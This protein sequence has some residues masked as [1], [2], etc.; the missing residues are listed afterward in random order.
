RPWPVPPARQH[1]PAWEQRILAWHRARGSISRLHHEAE[2]QELGEALEA[3]EA[4]AE[5][6]AVHRQAV[7]VVH[8]VLARLD[9]T[10]QAVLR[11]GTAGEQAGVPRYPARTRWHSFTYQEFG[12]GAPRDKGVLVLSTLGRIAVPWARPVAGPP[13]TVTRSR[14]ADGGA[15]LCSGA[16]VPGQR[17]AA[18]GHQPGIDLGSE[19]F[20]PRSHGTRRFAPSWDR[21]AAP[22]LKPAQ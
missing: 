4:L 12:N 22:A 11:R 17:V 6:A 7:Q 21:T 14:A 2:V 5:Y 20:A 18:P 15:V 3:L 10:S 8:D 9:K 1:N 13:T 19:A 16:E